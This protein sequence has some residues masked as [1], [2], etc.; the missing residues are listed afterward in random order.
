MENKIN[1]QEINA[2]EINATMEK[3]NAILRARLP[4][5]NEQNLNFEART[6]N[7][8]KASTYTNEDGEEK[9]RRMVVE[10]SLIPTECADEMEIKRA[11]ACVKFHA[12]KVEKQQTVID[13][14]KK[15]LAEAKE[16]LATLNADHAKA[17]E[18]VEAFELPEKEKTARVTLT[19]KVEKQASEID[20]LRAMLA[21]AGIDPDSVQA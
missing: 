7:F 12:S 17:V 8:F 4:K 20:R 19:A 2:Q 6:G 9:L 11:A 16:Y 14:C 10:D 18:L 1:A 5:L 13:E 3:A 21:A 15:A